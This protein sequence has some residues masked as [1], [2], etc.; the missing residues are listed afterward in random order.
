MDYPVETKELIQ[1]FGSDAAGGLS[2][3]TAA[4]LLAQHGPNE[5]AATRRESPWLILLHQFMSPVIYLLLIAMGMSLFFKEWLDAIAIAV[6][7]LL[8][9][10]IGFIME[11]QAE[12]AMDALRQMT[13]QSARVLRGGK[14]TEIPSTEIV[15]GDI[16]LL[17]A[18][19]MVQADGRIIESTSLQADE[20]A[21]TGESLPVD[22]SPVSSPKIPRWPSGPIWSTRAR[23]SA[24]AMHACSAPQRG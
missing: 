15:P 12:K 3:D 13:T 4:R 21:L 22:K 7:I 2:P 23:I 6:V 18:G 17:D 9:A 10:L 8:N 11:F 1:Q 14:V 20:S 5:L 16:I 24:T 19:D